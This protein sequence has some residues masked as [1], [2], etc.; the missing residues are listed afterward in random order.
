MVEALLPSHLKSFFQNLGH[1]PGVRRT[2]PA[3]LAAN[4]LNHTW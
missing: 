2:A 4:H 3:R 1:G